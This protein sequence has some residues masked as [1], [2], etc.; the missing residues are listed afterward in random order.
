MGQRSQIYVRFFDGEKIRLIAN[1][2]SWNYGE[3]MISRA[4]YGIET[5]KTILGFNGLHY[6][7][8]TNI[9]KLQRIF[10]VNFD[11]C[12]Y[13]VSADIISEWKELAPDDNFNDYVF[14][15]Q[16]NNDGKLF[17]DID[18]QEGIIKY[19]FT[20][21]IANPDNIMNGEEYMIWNMGEKWEESD[22]LK[23]NTVLKCKRNIKSISKNAQLMSKE[24]LIE[25]LDFDYTN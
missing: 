2:Y 18:T 3:R 9:T 14:R 21:Y 16:H 5:I 7:F 11:M 12:D 17:I 15:L 22:Y 8:S 23:K 13:Q 20:D 1:Y 4:R 10:D 6:N 24:E 19:A 25:F